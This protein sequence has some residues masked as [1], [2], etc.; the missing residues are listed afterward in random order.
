MLA[1]LSLPS[2]PARAELGKRAKKVF[3]AFSKS[4][5]LPGEEYGH[6]ATS[7]RV[8]QDRDL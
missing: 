7:S 8:A 6:S 5:G 4:C 3:L 2:H 1:A